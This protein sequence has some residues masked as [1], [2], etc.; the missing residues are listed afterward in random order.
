VPVARAEAG[1]RSRDWNS[2]E[3]KARRAA[4][5]KG[6]IFFCATPGTAENMRAEGAEQVYVTGDLVL[7]AAML[8]AQEAGFQSH[9]LRRL[10]IA[11]KPRQAGVHVDAP[12]ALA[13]FSR[14]ETTGAP[15]RLAALYQDLC[16]IAGECRVIW[17]VDP[18]TETAVAAL[19]TDNAN[20]AQGLTITG[21]AGYFDMLELYKRAGV[22]IT[23]SGMVQREAYFF[24]KPSVLV[25]H[26]TDW[27]ELVE[28]GVSRLADGGPGAVLEAW[29]EARGMAVRFDKTL[30]GDGDAAGRIIETLVGAG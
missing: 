6:D 16:Q 30:F 7:D 15:E 21:T 10:D 25:R 9:I 4:D 1:V 26:R 29:R 27:P 3:D 8:H 18:E 12:V 11:P 14:P 13:V 22:V 19:D 2:P 17:P 28:K 5:Q 23:D 24:H 20:R